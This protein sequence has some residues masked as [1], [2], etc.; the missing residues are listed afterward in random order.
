MDAKTNK[1]IKRREA[2]IDVA[3]K[4]FDNFGIKGAMLS[5]IAQELDLSKNS[6]NYYFKRKEDL[7]FACLK[8][9][10]DTFN[11]CVD[12]SLNNF[13]LED[14]IKNF[15]NEFFKKVLFSYEGKYPSLMTFRDVEEL[16]AKY[17]SLIY[18]E[19]SKMF[20]K[21]RDFLFDRTVPT[22]KIKFLV[23][24]HVILTQ[25][26]WARIWLKDDLLCNFDKVLDEYN[27]VIING[28]SADFSNGIDFDFFTKKSKLNNIHIDND[29]LNYDFISA[30]VHVINS[31]SYE[32]ASI[33]KISA[34]INLTKGAFYHYIPNKDELFLECIYRTKFVIDNAMEIM[35]DED[36]NSLQKLFIFCFDLINFHFSKKGPLLRPYAWEK[37]D[38]FEKFYEKNFFIKA[39]IHKL[40]NLILDGMRDGSIRIG[41]QKMMTMMIIGILSGGLS[42]NKWTL[43]NPSVEAKEIYLR[44]FF[45][46]LLG[47][48]TS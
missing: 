40:N 17:T 27:G 34:K 26:Q 6:L 37:N 23:S 43:G 22:D 33:D 41:H 24:T 32:G 8:H 5:D 16:D 18:L 25:A 48:K 15:H 4:H 35:R 10:I 39:L 38:N 9:T 21:I 14:R 1:F 20:K 46:G 28:Y 7:V 47:D 45:F 3:S 29:E 2:I 31:S 44:K 12:A 36:I 13:S 19:Y 42:L 11:D 30:A